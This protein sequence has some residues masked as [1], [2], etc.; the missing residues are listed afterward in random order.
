MLK[1]LWK[2][3]ILLILLILILWLVPVTVSVPEQSATECIVTAIAIDKKESDYEVTLQYINPAEATA[4]QSLKTAT[5]KDKSV[6][7]AMEKVNA[8]LGQISGIAHCRVVVF[9]EEACEDNFTNIL[10]S[11][12]RQKTNT[13][14][15]IL[16]CST[17]SAKDVLSTAKNLDSNL[18]SFLNNSAFSNELKH[19]EDLITV[20]DY[21]E[22]YFGLNKCSKINII[23]AK[24]QQDSSSSVS[25]GGASS[26]GGESS[27]S[28]GAS[29]GGSSEKP[30]EISNEGKAIIIKN[31][32][33]LVKLSSE[34]SDN[35]DWFNKD[36]N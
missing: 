31:A 33:K 7:G 9:N 2:N 21:Y 1:R 12:S 13:N 15:M 35:L 5:A 10:D 8:Q 27:F 3:K 36:I 23:D 19:Y 18:Y 29:G 6:Y 25:A 14:N 30:K 22:S 16:V 20:G 24:E 28:G 34:Q 11:F 32:K 4:T 17:K 26:G